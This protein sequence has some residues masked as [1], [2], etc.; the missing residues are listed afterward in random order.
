MNRK[1]HSVDVPLSLTRTHGDLVFASGQVGRVPETGT[2]PESFEAQ[3]RQGIENLRSA[4]AGA[5]SSLSRVLKTTVFIRREGDFSQMN[6]I[7]ASMFEEPYP[8]RTTI[9]TALARPEI[10]FEI[11]AI[12]HTG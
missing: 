5:S 8:A 6:E 1:E 11:E 9:V 4:L 10:H 3:A 12:A 7:Y 2:I